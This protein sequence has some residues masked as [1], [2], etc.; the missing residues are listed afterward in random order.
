MCARLCEEVETIDPEVVQPERAGSGWWARARGSWERAVQGAQRPRCCS[1][2]SLRDVI[3]KTSCESEIIPTVFRLL[4][5]S[6]IWQALTGH[7][8]CVDAVLSYLEKILHRVWFLFL[9]SRCFPFCLY[10][11]HF[12]CTHRLA[13]VAFPTS[14]STVLFKKNILRVIYMVF[15]VL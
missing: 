10:V 11:F 6:R 1:V 15:L 2:E 13:V 3:G 14:V 7:T 5:L 9:L 8:G 4:H 12:V